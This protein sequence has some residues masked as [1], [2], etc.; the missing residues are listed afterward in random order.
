VR[1]VDKNY[2]QG[3]KYAVFGV[4]DS[5]Y[6]AHFNTVA[7]NIAEWVGLRAATLVCATYGDASVDIEVDFSTFCE[8]LLTSQTKP[9]A[10]EGCGDGCACVES[11]G[12]GLSGGCKSS[13]GAEES[14]EEEVPREVPYYEDQEEDAAVLAGRDWVAESLK[15]DDEE[16]Y[17]DDED[18]DVE[19]EAPPPMMDMEDLGNSLKPAK[20][21]TDITNQGSKEMLTDP[22]RKALTKQGYKLVGSHS[23][24]KL[25]RWTKSMLRGRGGC[26]KHT[27]YGIASHRC[28]EVTCHPASPPLL[29]LWGK[30]GAT[31]PG[32]PEPDSAG[33]SLTSRCACRLHHLLP[34]PT[35]VS[36]VGATTRTPSAA[37]GAGPWTPRRKSWKRPSPSTSR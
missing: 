33:P 34:A 2:L 36:S 18:D 13:M 30:G 10:E 25:C 29:T 24:V 21:M 16:G 26:Y 5:S 35:S 19:T 11:S 12:A 32:P 8:E 23:G 28:M 3:L 37:S 22:L 9:K 6:G 20:K 15:Q 1:Q 7:K 31:P 17:S 14:E 4:G 27:F